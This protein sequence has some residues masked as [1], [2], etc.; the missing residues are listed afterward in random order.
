[1]LMTRNMFARLQ[2]TSQKVY[3]ATYRQAKF[4]LHHYYFF[5]KSS[6][7]SGYTNVIMIPRSVTCSSTNKTLCRAENL[8]FRIRRVADVAFPV[9]RRRRVRKDKLPKKMFRDLV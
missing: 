7:F 6:D 8:L 5:G 3:F 1:M 2:K 4:V 9:T